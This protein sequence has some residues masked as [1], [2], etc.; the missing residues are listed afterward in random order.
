MVN[1][2]I[3]KNNFSRYARYYDRYST[4]QNLCALRLVDKVNGNSYKKIL[5]IGC[6]TGNYTKL[7]KDKFPEA[8]IKAIDI[9]GEMVK[10]AKEKLQNEEIEFI[11]AD[12][13]TAN[14][15]EQFDFISSNA[16]FQWFENLEGFLLRYKKFFNENG[17]ILFSIFGP[18]TFYEL[19]ESLK[20]L[21]G[22]D[23]SISSCNFIK[24]GK[25]EEILKRLFKKVMIEEHIYKQTHNSLSELLKR[26]KY[27]GARGNGI[28]S[29]KL[30]T[31]GMVYNLEKIY[32][33][34][35][36]D[37]VTTYQVFFCKASEK[38]PKITS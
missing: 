13:E 34:K 21:S 26:I 12:A 27:T 2:E 24:K 7:L 14:L 15:Q 22:G 28:N 19:N 29:K 4:I 31:P 8:C 11:V 36:K 1:K 32:K 35:F 17:I 18:L 5:D 20:E 10:V 33:R 9:S 30:W 3:I 37:I 38:L 16:S 6:G 25:I 23:K